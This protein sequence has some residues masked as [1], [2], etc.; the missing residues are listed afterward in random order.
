MD[1]LF[2]FYTIIKVPHITKKFHFEKIVISYPP[3]CGKHNENRKTLDL[4]FIIN[5]KEVA[6]IN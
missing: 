2:S 4:R 1:L 6:G 3:C 5:K